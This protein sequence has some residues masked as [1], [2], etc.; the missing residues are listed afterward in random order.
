MTDDYFETFLNKVLN[1]EI[2]EVDKEAIK[3]LQALEKKVI[4]ELPISKG[5]INIGPYDYIFYWE[6]QPTPEP[7]LTLIEHIDESFAGIPAR[8]SITTEGYYTS[9]L[10]AERANG[11]AWL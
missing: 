3:R 7:L 10:T 1:V 2:E 8:F 6:K 5:V 4:K 11:Q 9:R